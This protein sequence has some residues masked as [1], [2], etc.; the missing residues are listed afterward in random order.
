MRFATSILLLLILSSTAAP[1]QP[2][3]EQ[4]GAMNVKVT[5]QGDSWVIAGKRTTVSLNKTDLAIS[6]LAGTAQW[7]MVGSAAGDIIVKSGAE[8]ASLR[9]ADAKQVAIVPYDA[10][11]KSGIKISLAGW[12]HKDRVLDLQLF[13]T[14][15][16]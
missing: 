8:E 9:L 6:V 13:L 15:C 4:W 1:Q 3:R 12:T 11:F 14:V 10:G 16:L 7:K 2:S 5:Q